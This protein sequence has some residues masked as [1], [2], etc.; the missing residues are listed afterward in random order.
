LL[1]I[2]LHTI[3]YPGDKPNT[4]IEEDM[5][6]EVISLETL[7]PIGIIELTSYPLGLEIIYGPY[8]Y[9]DWPDI[10]LVMRKLVQDLLNKEVTLLSS[11][12][13]LIVEPKEID[14]VDAVKEH[15]DKNPTIDGNKAEKQPVL[16]IITNAESDQEHPLAILLDVEFMRQFYRGYALDTAREIINAFP[17]AWNRYKHT[18][19]QWG[20]SLFKNLVHVTAPTVGRYLKAFQEAG[21]YEIEAIPVPHRRKSSQ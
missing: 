11:A 21:V 3:A 9:K 1:S 6:W 20:P 18:G 4:I 17:E 16:G 15:D 7:E 10:R 13:K 2:R 14:D 19:E 12:G 8:K 5:G